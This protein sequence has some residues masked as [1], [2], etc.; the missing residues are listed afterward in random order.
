MVDK[1]V[2]LQ[3]ALNPVPLPRKLAILTTIFLPTGTGPP[4][5]PWYLWCSVKKLIN[6]LTTSLQWTYDTTS[7]V[8]TP[9]WINTDGC[10]FL[11]LLDND[12]RSHVFAQL[13]PTRNSSPW[14]PHSTSVVAKIHSVTSTA[15][16]SA[17][18][19]LRPVCVFAWI[20]PTRNSGTWAGF[21][22]SVVTGQVHY[23]VKSVTLLPPS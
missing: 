23:Y 7:R 11:V 18:C 9:Q 5:L 15:L 3:L 4:S 13:L 21:S 19:V 14:A 22:T 17:S 6:F 2:E 16:I 12:G 8:L 1:I 20:P 10:M